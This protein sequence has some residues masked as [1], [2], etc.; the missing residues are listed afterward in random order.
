MSESTAAGFS[1]FGTPLNEETL[2]AS[3]CSGY[4]V[5]VVK[6]ES[7]EIIPFHEGEIA[8]I[9]EACFN[10]ET[11]ADF[12]HHPLLEAGGHD[13]PNSRPLGAIPKSKPVNIPPPKR[14]ESYP[15]I[16]EATPPTWRGRLN[17][18]WPLNPLNHYEKPVAPVDG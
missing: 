8:S 18:T 9:R 14:D 10:P 1:V 17:S 16:P 15:A 13:Y 7:D 4:S 5:V 2:L 11:V 12:G 6:Q 3:Q